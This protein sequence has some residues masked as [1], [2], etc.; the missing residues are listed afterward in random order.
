MVTWDIL[1]GP[2]PFHLTVHV[3]ISFTN[4][5]IVKQDNECNWDIYKES[6]FHIQT[7]QLIYIAVLITFYERD[8]V[9]KLDKL[10]ISSSTDHHQAQIIHKKPVYKK[11]RTS[12]SKE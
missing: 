3:L 10:L 5:L 9:L 2:A 7:N 11:P 4:I 6:S 12:A 1:R 8:I